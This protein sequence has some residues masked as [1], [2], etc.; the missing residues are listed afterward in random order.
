MGRRF[1]V[2]GAGPAGLAAAHQLCAAGARVD[3]FERSDAVGGLARSL[4][5]WGR[6]VDLGPHVLA[7]GDARAHSLLDTLIGEDYVDVPVRRGVLLPDGTLLDYPLRG[8]S[9]LR[10]LPLSVMAALARDA[11]LAR[12]WR[13]DDARSA[14]R[15]VVSRYGRRAYD[16]LLCPFIEKMWGREGEAIDVSFVR[17]VAANARDR[18]PGKARTFRYPAHGL[19]TLWTRLLDRLGERCT[20]HCGTTVDDVVVRDGRVR[21]LR[22]NGVVESFD[23]VVSSMPLG[24]LVPLLPHAPEGATRLET[25]HIVVVHLRV[26]NAARLPFASLFVADRSNAIGRVSDSRVWN[27]ESADDTIL[28]LECW[29]GEQDAA[30]ASDDDEVLM[31]AEAQ[32]RA[33]PPYRDARPLAGHVTRLR[34]A[35][36]V[37]TLGITERVVRLAAHVNGIRG[38]RSVGRHGGFLYD[39]TADSIASGMRGADEVLAMSAL[40]SPPSQIRAL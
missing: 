2:I 13:S 40:A 20:V 31:R 1:A 6:T 24:R 38:L 33:L 10:A 29:C 37:P 23:G 36:P 5:L 9:L 12:V 11:L 30:W 16:L 19:Q 18:H 28:T 8:S 14:E 22:V 34:G 25:R 4:E 27:G 21:G 32:L 39:S 7:G 17:P 35:L 26:A 3:V 15:W